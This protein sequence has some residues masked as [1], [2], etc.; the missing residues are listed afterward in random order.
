MHFGVIAARILDLKNATPIGSIP[1]VRD[2]GT[3]YLEAHRVCRRKVKTCGSHYKTSPGGLPLS[4]WT[5]T[6]LLVR[7][8]DG[9]TPVSI[10]L[11]STGE[12]AG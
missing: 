6:R 1:A 4:S 11:H 12:S 7:H 9:S 10:S 2:M 8:V 5:V 3:A